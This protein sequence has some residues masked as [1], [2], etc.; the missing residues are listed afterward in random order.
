M[1]RTTQQSSEPATQTELASAAVTLAETEALAAH[2][3]SISIR[4]NR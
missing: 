4:L 1:K 3:R 2:G